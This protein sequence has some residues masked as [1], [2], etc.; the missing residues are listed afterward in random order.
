PTWRVWLLPL[1]VAYVAFALLTWLAGPL[2]NLLLRMSR[3]GRLALS[4]E[5]TWAAN[6]FGLEVLAALGLLIGAFAIG[7]PILLIAALY[8]GLLMLPSAAIFACPQ[9]WP[10][11]VMAGCTLA[12]GVA[13]L[14]SL[15]QAR[16]VG[17]EV[18]TTQ[19]GQSADSLFLFGII[20]SQFLANSLA[21]VRIRK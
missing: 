6:L 8:T 13:A 18:A 3:F 17:N 12:L 14:I 11:W 15:T 19:L 21:N 16:I 2:F 5:Q 7:N 4:R 9:G 10:R 20:G 1:I